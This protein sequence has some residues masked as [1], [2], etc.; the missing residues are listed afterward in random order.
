MTSRLH[1]DDTREQRSKRRRSST[2]EDIHKTSGNQSR[3]TKRR[4]N[5]YRSRRTGSE[6]VPC[7]DPASTQ[8]LVQKPCRFVFTAGGSSGHDP[9]QAA[10]Y[11]APE[12]VPAQYDEL[13]EGELV[14]SSPL[15]HALQRILLSIG[16]LQRNSALALALT[17]TSLENLRSG[18]S[19]SSLRAGL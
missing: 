10:V 2:C 1:A 3:Q 6:N 15:H 12:L 13:E 17:M 9:K 7:P 14:N 18:H 4:Q 16:L 11:D 19:N 8:A 5:T